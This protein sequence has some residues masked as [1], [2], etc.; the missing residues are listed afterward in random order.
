[1]KKEEPLEKK[2]DEWLRKKKGGR[3]EGRRGKSARELYI[4]KQM[5]GSRRNSITP[6]P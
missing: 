5:K 6:C 2:E 3:R 1:M 4:G